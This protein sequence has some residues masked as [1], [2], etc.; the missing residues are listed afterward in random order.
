MEGDPSTDTVHI[1]QVLCLKCVLSSVIWSSLQ[2]LWHNFGGLNTNDTHRSTYL[3]IN[4]VALFERISR[5]GRFGVAAVFLEE[6]CALV[7]QK[8]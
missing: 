8:L 6:V 4:G 2:F 1:L 3:F 7:F 5:C